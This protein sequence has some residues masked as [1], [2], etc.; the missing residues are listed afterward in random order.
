MANRYEI[1]FKEKLEQQYNKPVLDV[2]IDFRN[3]GL[4]IKEV[5]ELTGFR[6][7]TVRIWCA[8]YGI[9]LFSLGQKFHCRPKK[10][11]KKEMSFI[12]QFHSKTL[13]TFNVLSRKW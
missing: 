11:P 1:P 8:K 3:Q 4:T 6:Y 5:A 10:A 2:L 7:N 13:N 12:A 9:H